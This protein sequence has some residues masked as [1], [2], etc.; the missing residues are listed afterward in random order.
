MSVRAASLAA[1]PVLRA[2]AV[3]GSGEVHLEKAVGVEGKMLINP[4]ASVFGCV[5][6]SLGRE[7]KGELAKGE[8]DGDERGVEGGE[9]RTRLVPRI[10]TESAGLP[11]APAASGLGAGSPALRRR[12]EPGSWGPPRFAQLQ[13]EAKPKSQSARLQTP[14][15]P[16]SWERE[17]QQ[18]Y[19][20]CIFILLNRGGG[21]SDRLKPGTAKPEQTL[22]EINERM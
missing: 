15:H 3:R 13:Q 4:P 2:A 21:F 7:G 19:K 20:P 10:G 5:R 16:I 22:S 17:L 14:R 1:N 18:N 11:S 9:R 6:R 8:E 12:A